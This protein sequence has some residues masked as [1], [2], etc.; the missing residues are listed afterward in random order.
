MIRR[1]LYDVDMKKFS[2]LLFFL[3][4][5]TFAVA[6]PLPDVSGSW[7]KRAVTTSIADL[8]VIGEVETTTEAFLWVT[9]TQDR[10]RLDIKSETCFAEL[11]GDVK[12]VRMFLPGAF[13]GVMKY[14]RKGT[15]TKED[16]QILFRQ[17][18]GEDVF[19]AKLAEFKDA[20][21]EKSDDPRVID[22]DGDGFPGVTVK[23]R[24]LV[25]GSIYLTQ[26]SWSTMRGL[27]TGDE[28]SG[29]IRWNSTQSVLGATSVF[30]RS[31]PK[32]KPSK[33]PTKN[34]FRMVKAPGAASCADA[35]KQREKFK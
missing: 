22:Q 20:L 25:T 10:G 23:T 16:G 30:L 8:P 27:V 11:T 21:P 18:R 1:S 12:K 19:G 9:V 34:Y 5:P 26:K 14:K 32:A 7:L 15:L 6:E 29:T 31:N 33:D 24:G 17:T 13:V 2:V 4:A 35:M 28:I 3:W